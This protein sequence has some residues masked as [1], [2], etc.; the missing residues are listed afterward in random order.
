LGLF[1]VNNSPNTLD[2]G[3]RTALIAHANTLS[4]VSIELS[5]ALLGRSTGG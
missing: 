1:S 3:F 5:K 2:V 4:R